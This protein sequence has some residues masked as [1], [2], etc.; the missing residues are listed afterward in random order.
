M[1]H[2]VHGDSLAAQLE[3]ESQ[4]RSTLDHYNRRSGLFEEG[5]RERLG[6]L[7]EAQPP[8]LPYTPARDGWPFVPTRSP[9]HRTFD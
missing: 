9:F 5:D 4:T 7:R 3:R 6:G 1:N 2:S 8:G